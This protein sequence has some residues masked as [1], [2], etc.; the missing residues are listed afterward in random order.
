MTIYSG[1]LVSSTVA[2]NGYTLS[3]ASGSIL[4]G[5]GG[6][7]AGT[8]IS[9]GNT[10]TTLGVLIGPASASSID[11]AGTG[12]GTNPG[13]WVVTAANTYTGPTTIGGGIT[14]VE[15]N[16]ALGTSGAVTVVGGASLQFRA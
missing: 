3:G 5:Q 11:F 14:Q 1:G 2:G 12:T 15:N 8:L 7:S 13:T 10:T 4:F 6:G 9:N 16:T